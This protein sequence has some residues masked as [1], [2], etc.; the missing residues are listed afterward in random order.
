MELGKLFLVQMASR[1]ERIVL[2]QVVSDHDAPPKRCYAEEGE[3][4]QEE[5]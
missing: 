1:A 4:H 3:P 5:R 2:F